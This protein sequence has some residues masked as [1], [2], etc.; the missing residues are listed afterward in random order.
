MGTK[1]SDWAVKMLK[2]HFNKKS[3]KSVVSGITKA[4]EERE[5]FYRQYGLGSSK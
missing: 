2:K 4:A 1:A 5:E 3:N